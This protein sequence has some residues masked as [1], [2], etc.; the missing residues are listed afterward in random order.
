MKAHDVV[1]RALRENGVEVVFSLMSDGTKTLVAKLQ[2]RDDVSV[3]EARHEQNAMAMADGYARATGEVGVC[4]VGRGPAIAQTGTSL[5]TAN[6]HGSKLLVLAPESPLSVEYDVKRF[7]QE[8]FLRMMAGDVVSIRSPDTLVSRITNV[9]RRL[10]RG[11]GPIVV[12]VPWDLMNDEVPVPDDWDPVASPSESK[13]RV[14][15]PPESAEAAVDLYL[16]SAA[17]A[18]PVILAG[19]GAVRADAAEVLEDLAERTGAILTTTLQAKGY[20]ADHPFAPGF[21]GTFGAGL[22]NQY[23]N[24][25][26]FVFA[27]GCSLN[28]HTTDHGRLLEDTT[29]VHADVEPTNLGVYATVDLGIHGDARETAR[30]VERVLADE[31]LDFSD[32]FWTANRRHHIAE[33][34]ALDDREYPEKP[35]RIDPRDLVR[36]LDTTLPSD[37]RVVVDGGHFVNFVLDGISVPSPDDFVWSLDFASV[38]QGVPMGIGAAAREDDRPCIT[39]CGDAGFMMTIQE[40]NTLAREEIPITIVVMNDEALGSEYHQLDLAGKNAAAARS[41]TPDFA[42]VAEDFGVRGYTIQSINDIEAISDELSRPP[43]DPRVVDCKINREVRHRFYLD[44]HGF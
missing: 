7:E 32:M 2:K 1:R 42:D 23:L 29:V 25:S 12:Q 17:T 10:D 13:G 27:V 15:P 6:K 37:R 22:A 39:F 4:T 36:K 19:R 28:P 8:S 14:H 20:F 40:L 26:D 33:T 24:E 16:D 9:F 30:A 38:G 44:L 31:G 11:D 35:E 43:D 21:V 34:S 3:L 18:P 41:E 5:V